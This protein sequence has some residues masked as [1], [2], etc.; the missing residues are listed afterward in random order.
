V[1]IMLVLIAVSIFLAARMKP[2]RDPLTAEGPH[3]PVNRTPQTIFLF[4]VIACVLYVIYDIWD[5]AF[6]GKVFPMSVAL[7][8]LALLIA[9]AVLLRRGNPNYAYFDSERE[10][11]G[12]EKPLKSDLHY[13]TWILGLLAAVA[14]VGF[15]LGIF[16]YIVA[17]LR[18]KA[19]ARWH[20]AVI[21]ALG[22]IGVLSI[23]GHFLILDYPEGLLQN[24]FD[25]PWPIN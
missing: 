21:G 17:F 9:I 4:V 18:V 2:M 1:Q 11:A 23:F 6:L 14:V 15:I 13:Q 19:G 22:A 10:W 24:F 20:W 12:E 25:L 3:A 5:L 16:I 8:T 7:I